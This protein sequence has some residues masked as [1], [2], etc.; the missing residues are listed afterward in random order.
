MATPRHP[1]PFAA[2]RLVIARQRRGLRRATLAARAGVSLRSLCSYETNAQQPTRRTVERL[3]RA[4]GFPL[5]YFFATDLEPV[6]SETV[7]FRAL[8]RLGAVQR[9]RAL[10]SA[11]FAVALD[12]WFGQRFVMPTADLPS[13]QSMN[14]EAAA[15]ALREAWSLGDRPIANMVHLLE[16]RGV[17]VYSL[18]DECADVDAF[19]W[20][21]S[22]TP[23]VFLNTD[24]TAERSRMDAAH[25]LG[26]LVLH[27]GAT[28]PPRGRE[29]E[30][31][32]QT[33]GSAF[34]MPAASVYRHAPRSARLDHIHEAKGFW[35]V[36]AA[37]LVHRMHR[38]GVLS[39]WQYRTLFVELGATGQRRTEMLGIPRET[40][41]ALEKL[42]RSL[43]EHDGMSKADIAAALRLPLDEVNR[44]VFGLVP[45]AIAGMSPTKS[46]SND[47]GTPPHRPALTVVRPLRRCPAR[48]NG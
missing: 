9:D 10:A 24:K 8:S 19:S 44:I 13:L 30:N 39:D 46:R 43:R 1:S 29:A 26:H 2:G 15:E 35:R 48:E 14:P 11:A 42:F 38:L 22:G 36:S 40:S 7:S 18:A 4:L 25:E 12:E 34:L 3:A 20:W 41:L 5:A 31:D 16:S 6:G 21:R 17:R 28:A 33:F 23:Y 32:A 27:A 47:R 45:T 37:N